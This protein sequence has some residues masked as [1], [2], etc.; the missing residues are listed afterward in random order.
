[1]WK[2]VSNRFLTI[3]EVTLTKEASNEEKK[4]VGYHAPIAGKG[5][6]LTKEAWENNEK[7]INENETHVQDGSLS[8]HLEAV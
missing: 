7:E 5:D 3:L 8:R 1:M 4:H 2:Y 6:Y